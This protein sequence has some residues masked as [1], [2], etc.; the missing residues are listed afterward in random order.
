MQGYWFTFVD[1]PA[2]YADTIV[3]FNPA[4]GDSIQLIG[5]DTPSY[6]LAHATQVNG[7]QDT[8][9]VLNDGSTIL[10]KGVSQ[11][12]GSFFS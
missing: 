6:A 4:L 7:G 9:M 10:L 2:T 5:D 1:G 12:D 11:I 3:G 8:L